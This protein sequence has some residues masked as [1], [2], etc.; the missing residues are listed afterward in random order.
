MQLEVKGRLID[1]PIKTILETIKRECPH[2]ILHDIVDKERDKNVTITCPFHK[3]GAENKPSCHVFKEED[4]PKVTYG[5]V[6]CFT[7]GYSASL[8]QFVADCFGEEYSFGEQWLMERFGNILL[9]KNV[10][11]PEIKLDSSPKQVKGLSE[12]ALAQYDY[13]H[14]YM[15][16]RGLTKE[17]IDMFRVGYDSKRDAITFP[18]WDD[19]GVPLFV[20]ARSVRDKKFY[21]PFE[22]EK[23]VYL[24][25]FVKKWGID[26]VCITEGQIDALTA[27][28]YGYPCIATMGTPSDYQLNLLNHSGIRSYITMF[29]NDV[30]GQR[31]TA[32]FKAKMR[33]DVWISTASFPPGKKDINNLSKEEF[34]NSINSL[35]ETFL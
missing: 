26:S 34:W 25:N 22:A 14:P 35:K 11:L 31:F 32:L 15:Y 30:A 21:I 19:K 7:C 4:D 33:K 9:Q 29:D 3:N 2:P 5:T 24:L 8:P 17:V 27:W 16:Q 28:G 6:H 18:V 23:P 1:A 10:L 12:E 20:T 13:Y